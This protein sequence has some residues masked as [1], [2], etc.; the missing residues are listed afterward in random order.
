MTAGPRL[1][2]SHLEHGVP[3][4]VDRQI[5]VDRY[6]VLNPYVVIQGQMA[7]LTYN[8]VNYIRDADRSES[9]GR[10]WNSTT[11]FGR[12]GDLWKTIHSHWSFTRHSA[13][14]TMTAE[15]SERQRD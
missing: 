11:V 6:E 15:A 10:C 5:Q 2:L 8:P 14:Q 13:F 12:R 7:L 9:V 4:A 1:D 3:P